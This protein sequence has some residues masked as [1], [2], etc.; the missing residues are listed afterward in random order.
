MGQSQSSNRRLD[1]SFELLQNTFAKVDEE[2]TEDTRKCC[3][4][5]PKT[6]VQ[7]GLDW[8]QYMIRQLNGLAFDR[9]PLILSKYLKSNHNHN[10]D[11]LYQ[12][13]V[14]Y[15]VSGE[16]LSIKKG[17]SQGTTNEVRG[18]PRGISINK[19]KGDSF[20]VHS[21]SYSNPEIEIDNLDESIRNLLY[22][23]TIVKEQLFPS[24]YTD[25]ADF[26]VADKENY[27]SLL[28][29]TRSM[30][31]P[32]DRFGSSSIVTNKR[33]AGY[34]NNTVLNQ[35]S[36]NCRFELQ[37]S[38][39][40][41]EM[42]DAIEYYKQ[43]VGIIEKQLKEEK[44]IFCQL[45]KLFQT[46]FVST[47]QN[48]IQEMKRDHTAHSVDVKVIERATLDL[49][50]FIRILCHSINLFYDLQNLKKG[51]VS[52]EYTVF[53]FDNISN[54]VTTMIFNEDIYN[55]I[56]ELYKFENK[57]LEKLY[58]RHLKASKKCAPQ[59]FGVPN[60][61]CLNELTLDH[62]SNKGVLVAR[63]VNS[64]KLRTRDTLTLGTLEDLEDSQKGGFELS[65]S[66]FSNRLSENS[67]SRGG[68]KYH[69]YEKSI[70]IL[71]QLRNQKSPIHKLKIIMKVVDSITNTIE[72]FY[73]EMN[74]KAPQNLT[75]E[76]NFAVFCYIL[77]KSGLKNVLAH[78]RIVQNF[79]TCNDMSSISGYYTTTLEI[80][81]R[82]VANMTV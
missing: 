7:R 19:M 32:Q 35:L 6:R 21:R 5:T 52:S 64:A 13:Q 34:T 22:P 73:R 72:S 59:D 36:Q 57:H 76:Q 75:G 14:I 63:C 62:L 53:N 25:T 69:P 18:R 31:N 56:Y 42:H 70:S 58:R 51:K 29:E 55:T 78:C 65:V 49:Q 54:F 79:S 30:D 28:S 33:L 41:P 40:L 74:Q 15:A 2:Y 67:S 39:N 81:Y 71:K 66:N 26:K 10:R 38:S 44:N 23:S 16:P 12:N 61:C 8:K 60:F 4:Y 82:H 24:T 27:S 20:V 9:W 48:K 37:N 50:H 45:M 11:I 1:Q 46:Y 17:K 80:C 77:V 43:I 68:G 47:Y 3:L